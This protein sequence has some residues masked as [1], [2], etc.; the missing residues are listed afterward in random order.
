MLDCSIVVASKKQFW[1]DFSLFAVVA[2]FMHFSIPSYEFRLSIP[3]VATECTYQSQQQLAEVRILILINKKHET[4]GG[5]ENS[6]IR[7]QINARA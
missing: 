2:F 3:S 1:D 7:A 6:K 5:E 4:G